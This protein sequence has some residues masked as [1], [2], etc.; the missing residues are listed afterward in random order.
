MKIIIACR[1][2]E[3]YKNRRNIYGGKGD[4]LTP[5][6]VVQIEELCKQLQAVVAK[7]PLPSSLYKSCERVQINESANLIAQ[8]LNIAQV[9]TDPQFRPIR[10]GVFDGMSREKQLEL[11]PSACEAHEKWEQGLIDIT[12][13]ESLVE[14]MQPALEYYNQVRGFLSNLPD[15]TINILMGTRSDLSCLENVF[16]NQSPAVPMQY[17]YNK[18]NYAEA[19]AC[20][21]L[22]DK[23]IK[24]TLDDIIHQTIDFDNVK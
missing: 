9:Q 7:N 24:C 15:N 4:G 23:I 13:S 14:G 16:N 1:H 5:E 19:T 8:N 6:G 2:G 20:V 18:F 3:A 21:M 22:G 17:R 12:E 11:Y 10:L